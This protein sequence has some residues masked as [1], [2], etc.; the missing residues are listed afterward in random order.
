MKKTLSYNFAL[1]LVTGLACLV[2]LLLHIF[3]PMRILPALNVPNAALLIVLS[4]A[5]A[6]L[7]AGRI[8]AISITGVLLSGVTVSALPLTVG[9]IDGAGALKLLGIGFFLSA[10]VWLILGELAK[11]LGARRM[12]KPT[13]VASAL[14]LVLAFQGFAGM[15]L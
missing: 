9:L 4:F 2:W 7:A 11:R 1:I 14:L 8:D 5:A 15:A 10:F 13:F 3:A 12:R 6:Y